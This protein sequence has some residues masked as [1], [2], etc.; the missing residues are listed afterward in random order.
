MLK[1]DWKKLPNNPLTGPGLIHEYC[2][3]EFVAD[4]M[5]RLLKLHEQHVA[6]GVRPEVEAA[7]LH[8]RFTQIHPFQDGNGRIARALATIVF[9]RSGFLPLVVRSDEESKDLYLR[10]LEHADNGDLAPLINLFAN[11]ETEDLEDAIAEVRELRSGASFQ[12]IAIAAADAAKRRAQED[13]DALA[14]TTDE[15]AKLAKNRLDEVAFEIGTV[16]RERDI[17]L[18]IAVEG[19]TQPQEHWWRESDH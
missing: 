1:G 2:P 14:Q 15:L 8:H 6:R 9:L 7:W 5:E 19:N 12:E 17:P 13:E 3:P 4:E 18:S 11:I 16:F 10:A